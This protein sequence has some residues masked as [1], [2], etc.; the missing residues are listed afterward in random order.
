MAEKLTSDSAVTVRC[1]DAIYD[2]IVRVM[3]MYAR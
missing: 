3:A 2:R 1:L